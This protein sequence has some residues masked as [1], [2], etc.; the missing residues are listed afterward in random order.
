MSD[1]I[2]PIV[3]MAVNV[4][5]QIVLFR[6]RRGTHY[7]GSIIQAFLCGALTCLVAESF[8]IVSSG[9]AGDRVF[10]ALAVNVPI[11]LG[12]SYCFYSFVQLGQTSIRLRMYSEIAGQAQ[13]VSLVEMEKEYDEH[14]LA[15][16]RLQ[17]LIES[18]DLVG[19]QEHY[20]IGKNRLVLIASVIF[21]AKHFL[22]RRKSE[23]D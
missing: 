15:E 8:F 19:Q 14:R 4:V 7:F 2:S 23:F 12:L 20:V 21:A 1:L 10:L 22:L 17:R 18:G 11:Y 13:G 16:M 6:L 9:F 3:A 5:V